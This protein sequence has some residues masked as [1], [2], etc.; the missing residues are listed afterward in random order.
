LKERYKVLEDEVEDLRSYGLA[1][2][3]RED[4]GYRRRKH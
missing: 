4:D 3:E 2:R 1:V